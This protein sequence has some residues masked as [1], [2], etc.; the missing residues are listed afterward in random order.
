MTPFEQIFRTA[1]A[2]GL[3]FGVSLPKNGVIPQDVW[4]SLHPLEQKIARTLQGKRKI[5]F[6]GGRVAARLGLKTIQQDR[7]GIDRDSMGAPIIA[8]PHSTL[9]VSISHKSDQAIAL[10]NRQRHVTVGVDLEHLNPPRLN[11]ASKVLTPVEFQ[12]WQKLPSERQWGY[13]LMT[14]SFKE[15]IYKA[16]APMWKRYIGFEEAEIFPQTDMT[17][18]VTLKPTKND[19]LPI[20]LNARYIWYEESIITSV[21]AQWR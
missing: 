20:K 19:I 9:T 3:Y 14:F 2:H 13:L 7:L 1:E 6:V 18:I 15:S 17:A 8:N 12:H 16:L 21:T 5:A 4:N 10:I 11:I